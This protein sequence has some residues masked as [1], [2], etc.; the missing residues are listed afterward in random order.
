M[1]DTPNFFPQMLSCQYIDG[2]FLNNN[3]GHRVHTYALPN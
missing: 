2:N 1:L 3:M